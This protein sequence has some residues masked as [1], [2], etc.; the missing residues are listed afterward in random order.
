MNNLPIKN[1]TADKYSPGDLQFSLKE[2]RFL[3]GG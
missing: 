2:P 1:K 3:K